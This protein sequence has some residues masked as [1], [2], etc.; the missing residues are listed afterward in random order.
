MKVGSVLAEAERLVMSLKST[1]ADAKEEDGTRLF[2]NY[3]SFPSTLFPRDVVFLFFIVV[4]CFLF[5]II[6]F[7]AASSP[8]VL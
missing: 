8:A 1:R 2:Q 5:L 7:Y 4:V 6:N 3:F